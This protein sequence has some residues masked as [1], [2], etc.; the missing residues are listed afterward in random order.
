MLKF[1]SNKLNLFGN[2]LQ[3]EIPK[4][5]EISETLLNHFREAKKTF[6]IEVKGERSKRSVNANAYLW[7]LLDKIALV[8]NTNKDEFYIEVL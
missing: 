5:T 4:G 6:R 1:T 2:I 7:V 8:L 3:I